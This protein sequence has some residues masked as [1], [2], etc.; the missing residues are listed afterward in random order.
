MRTKLLSAVLL[1]TTAIAGV[2]SAD[3]IVRDHRYDRTDRYSRYDRRYDRDRDDASQYRPAYRPAPSYGWSGRIHVTAR[4][5]WMSQVNYGYQVDGDGD[6]VT[7]YSY[8]QDPYV[9]GIARNQW[10]TLVDNMRLPSDRQSEMT[11]N[12]SGQ[13]L[14]SI[15]IQTANGGQ[16]WISGVW[17]FLNDGRRIPISVARYVDSSQPNLRLDLGAQAASG[18]RAIQIAG[19]SHA[20]GTFNVIG[21]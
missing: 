2:A 16:S 14:S 18:V 10:M 20:G 4:P 17:V 9:E 12:L 1:A 13:P 3:P 5:S 19:F 11:V 7:P 21:A 15:E 6:E 8:G